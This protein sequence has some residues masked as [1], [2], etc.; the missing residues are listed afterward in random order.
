MQDSVSLGSKESMPEVAEGEGKQ[1]ISGVDAE[2]SKG[3]NQS[4]K[5]RKSDY[6]L[7]QEAN[8]VWNIM[9]FKEIGEKYPLPDGFKPQPGKKANRMKGKRNE[10]EGPSRTSL[11]L[12][13]G[14]S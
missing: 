14:A 12:A 6:E 5:L 7:T 3:R 13:G 11:Q 2:G 1:D 8:I 10:K 4:Q 9:L